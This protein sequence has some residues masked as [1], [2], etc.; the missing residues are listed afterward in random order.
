MSSSELVRLE[1]LPYPVAS[2]RHIVDVRKF[3]SCCAITGN[4]NGVDLIETDG[5]SL[6][7]E[8]L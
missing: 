4:G 2:E 6:R 5:S 1:I 7:V 3:Q 8:I